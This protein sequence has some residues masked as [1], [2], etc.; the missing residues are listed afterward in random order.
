MHHES[1]RGPLHIPTP[2]KWFE[3]DV[4]VANV[5]LSVLQRK[6]INI[7]LRSGS[8]SAAPNMH[9]AYT[10]STPSNI[11]ACG[12]LK[13]SQLY[14]LRLNIPHRSCTTSEA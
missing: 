1:G 9:A 12:Y 13:I 7:P 4:T 6:F 11:A 5:L 10:G 14:Q 3:I 2:A 8:P